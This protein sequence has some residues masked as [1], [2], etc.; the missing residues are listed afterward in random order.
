MNKKPLIV[1]ID[2]GNTSAVA[3]F[4]LN[5]D[6]E[7]LES[8]KEFSNDEII[9]QLISTGKTVVVASDKKNIPSKAD[10]VARSL[11]ARKFEPLKDLSAERKEKIGKGDNSHEVD[12]YAS[13]LYAYNSLN[14]EIR[15]IKRYADQNEEYIGDVAKRYFSENRLEK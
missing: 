10:K 8:K 2:P 15:K 7:L 1:G 5:G 11:G 4:N 3:A 13:A 9:T 6:L 14:S 12:A